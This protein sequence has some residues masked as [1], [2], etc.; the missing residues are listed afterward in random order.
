MWLL[1]HRNAKTRAVRGGETFVQE[2]TECRVDARFV[3]VEIEENVGVW[4]VDVIGDTSRAYKCTSCGAVFDAKDE[5]DAPAAA[6]AKPL[7]PAKSAKELEIER[8]KAELARREQARAKATRVDDEL[9]E[10]K[11]RMGR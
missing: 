9:A 1:F 6:P 5:A 4:F 10:L 2:C 3:E 11:K 8:L 7:P